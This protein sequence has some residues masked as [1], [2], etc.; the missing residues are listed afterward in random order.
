MWGIFVAQR[1]G[2]KDFGKNAL[3]PGKKRR[4]QSDNSCPDVW[5][6]CCMPLTPNASTHTLSPNRQTQVGVY[7]RQ[8][9]QEN[10]REPRGMEPS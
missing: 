5:V 7:R 1:G 4:R 3:D 8:Q 10:E 2:R 6:R 9:G